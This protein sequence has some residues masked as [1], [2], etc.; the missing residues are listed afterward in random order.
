M[1]ESDDQSAR[2]SN[3]VLGHSD[4]ELDRLRRQAF[5]VN[6]ITRQFLIEAGIVS[7]M[8]V[9]DVGTGIGD[10]AFLAADLV[11]NAGQIVGVD[12]S[13]IALAAARKR[14]D[15]QSIRNV[16]F[17]E[18]DPTEIVFDRP[19]DAVVGR[20]VLCFQRDPSEMLQKIA[21][22]VRRGG[23]IVFDEINL[24]G[25][26]SFPSSPIYDMC[27]TW[28]EETMRLSGVD[29]RMGIKLHSAF[30]RAGL[31]APTMRVAAAVAAGANSSGIVEWV[32]ATVGTLLPE[33]ERLG[34]AT[35]ADVGFET[36]ADRVNREVSASG[37]VVIRHTDFGAWCRA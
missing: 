26:Q 37:S 30:V 1:N 18:G 14:T 3:Y 20:Y 31:T 32:V 12:R 10:V 4:R 15:V 35:A 13:P 21:T 2:S 36:L 8:R 34:V 29:T 23:L 7:G 27:C 9:L 25:A 6:P 11:G 17:R 28:V 16:L 22:L 33:I 24:H 19:F 5:Y